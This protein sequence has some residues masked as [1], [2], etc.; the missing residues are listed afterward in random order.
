MIR[1]ILGANRLMEAAHVRSIIPDNALCYG[2]GE[3]YV[4]APL[5]PKALPDGI[6]PRRR[7]SAAVPTNETSRASTEIP[8]MPITRAPLTLLKI[9]EMR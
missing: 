1:F 4:V 8:I 2:V 6:P 5:R 7:N 3:R 9:R